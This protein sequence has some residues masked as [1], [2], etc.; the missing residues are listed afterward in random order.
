MIRTKILPSLKSKLQSNILQNKEE[1]IG[2]LEKYQ[3]SIDLLQMID[4]TVLN[5][6]LNSKDLDQAQQVALYNAIVDEQMQLLEPVQLKLLKSFP[7]FL[8]FP[9]KEALLL[10]TEIA[11][12][13][14]ST[15]TSV[16]VISIQLLQE[17]LDVAYKNN[18][19][20]TDTL[21][22]AGTISQTNEA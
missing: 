17:Q 5:A 22:S 3:L 9:P 16:S 2:L 8:C 11:A 4:A 10:F 14:A 12:L 7:Y 13:I 18:T 21:R 20:L 19:V 6:L 15:H 1:T